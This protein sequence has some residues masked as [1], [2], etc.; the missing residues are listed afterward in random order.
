MQPGRRTS[1]GVTG[2]VSAGLVAVTL[3]G[4]APVATRAAVT[5]LSPLPLLVLKLG[6]ASLVLLPWAVPVFRKLRPRSAGRL[7]AAG[8]LGLV[9]YN[10]PVT[11]GL[12]WLPASTAGLLLATEPV[13]VLLLGSV[14]LAER[15]G[16]R[17]W[18]G[19]AIALGGVAVLAGPVAIT[20]SHGHQALAGAGL[21]LAG[22]LAFGAYTIVA[23]P[24]SQEYGAVPATAA[25]TV[26]GAIPYLPFAGTLAG[27]RM[28]DLPPLVWGEVAFLA[29]GSTVAGM[30][31]WNLAVLSGGATRV[32]L[33][34]YLE[35][36][37]SVLGAVAL[38]GERL[39][40]AAI[41]GGLLILAGVATA[42]TAR[43]A[44]PA[45]DPGADVRG[46]PG[47]G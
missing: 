6:L 14:F 15:N 44:G 31:L 38:L 27:A 34:L 4:L 16:A 9:G 32:S 46:L 2:P 13:W 7:L 20:G 26:V 30:L 33:L 42:G 25:C 28:T 35:P 40:A 10:L 11:A 22:T 23:R 18:L 47:P 3:W 1:Q 41:A 21:V 36:A 24:L 17:A 29:F 39:S 45:A 12:R 19:S 43:L 5:H 8:S 37:V